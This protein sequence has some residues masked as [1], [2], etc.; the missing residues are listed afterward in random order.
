MTYCTAAESNQACTHVYAWSCAAFFFF[1]FFFLPPLLKE[2]PE[3]LHIQHTCIHTHTCYQRLWVNAAFTQ[4]DGGA[5][6]ERLRVTLSR[7]LGKILAARSRFFLPGVMRQRLHPSLPLSHPPSSFAG[8]LFPCDAFKSVPMLIYLLLLLL[9]L[10][11]W[12]CVCASGGLPPCSTLAE[13]LTFL[14]YHFPSSPRSVAGAEE[15][16]GSG[17]ISLPLLSLSSLPALSL[18]P[19]S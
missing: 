2:S 19:S 10:W 1:F 16:I 18:P 9:L 6:H 7:S 13:L 5:V 15:K 11:F 4:R 12:W 17:W 8:S 14:K 3:H